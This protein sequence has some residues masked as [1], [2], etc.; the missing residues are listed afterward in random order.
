MHTNH[1]LAF[2]VEMM[3]NAWLMDAAFV[4]SCCH[5][6]GFLKQCLFQ[7]TVN[8]A[9]VST[10]RVNWTPEASEAVPGRWNCW[11]KDAVDIKQQKAVS[12]PVTLPGSD[13]VHIALKN[14][15][16]YNEV[17]CEEYTWKL[18]CKMRL[19]LNVTLSSRKTKQSKLTTCSLCL[20]DKYMNT[21][22]RQLQ[23]PEVLC[24]L[25]WPSS[26]K[27]PTQLIFC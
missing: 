17:G 15:T 13:S 27:F 8:A 5:H 20:I 21:K 7:H 22:L 11:S 1:L 16:N 10:V 9:E 2:G 14:I 24:Q 6:Y 18:L 23:V 19:P 4:K 3:S 26:K 12:L 25:N